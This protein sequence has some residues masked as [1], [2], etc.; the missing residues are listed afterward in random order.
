MR[1][2]LNGEIVE[3]AADDL[4]GLLAE[5]EF[6]PA[7]VAT[8]VNGDFVPRTARAG[9]RLEDGDKVEVISPRQGG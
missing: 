5:L 4:P 1:V 8:A 6:D 9:V 3:T 7:V 2:R